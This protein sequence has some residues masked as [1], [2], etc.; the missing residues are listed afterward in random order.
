M[1]GKQSTNKIHFIKLSVP[2]DLRVKYAELLCFRTP[3]P[4]MSIPKK[5]GIFL[6]G[7]IR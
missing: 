3:L 1:G 6:S 5:V 7:T 2:W 4:L